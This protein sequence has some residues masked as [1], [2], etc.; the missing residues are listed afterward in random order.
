MAAVPD[1]V[2][3]KAVKN[4]V[5]RIF[6]GG[7]TAETVVGLTALLVTWAQVLQWQT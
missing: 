5:G 6:R 7:F 1:A 3:Y 2:V 4:S